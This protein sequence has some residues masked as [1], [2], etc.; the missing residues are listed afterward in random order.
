[1]CL[2]LMQTERAN[3]SAL[4]VDAEMLEC[5]CTLHLCTAQI[6]RPGWPTLNIAQNNSPGKVY[7][8]SNSNVE[9]Y[10]DNWIHL[11]LLGGY[12]NG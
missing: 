1:M 4:K 8:W 6:N 9:N 7:S 2:G 5:L 3:M 12:V 10:G 11:V